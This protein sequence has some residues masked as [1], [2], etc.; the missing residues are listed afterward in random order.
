MRN[1]YPQASARNPGHAIP[2]VWGRPPMRAGARGW[3]WVMAAY[4]ED[5]CRDRVDEPPAAAF[6]RFLVW[7]RRST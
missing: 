2:P 3:R 5:F 7:T 1:P 6:E 4:L